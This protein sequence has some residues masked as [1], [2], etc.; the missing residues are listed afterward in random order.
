M[1]LRDLLIN[2]I[3]QGFITIFVVLIID[4][5]LFNLL[6][7]SYVDLLARNPNINP[8]ALQKMTEQF[9]LNKPLPEQFLLFIE[10]FVGFTINS[11]LHLFHLDLSIILKPLGLKSDFSLV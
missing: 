9:G 7:G 5:A 1:A 4:F 10:N 8:Q 3:L 11:F 6:P 2:R